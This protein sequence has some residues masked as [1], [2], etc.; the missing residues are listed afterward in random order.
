MI[1]RKKFLTLSSLGAIS[2]LFPNFIFS[3][4]NNEAAAFDLNGLLKNAKDLRKLGKNNEARQIYQQILIQFPNEIRAYDGL[5]KIIL[6]QKKKEWEVI[7]MFKAALIINP[8]NI[9]L[10]QRLYREYFNA[11]L[12]NKRIRATINFN[13]RLLA[14]VKQKFEIFLQSQPNNKSFQKQ[15]AKITRLLDCNADSICANANPTLKTYRKNSYKSFKNR[16][17]DVSTTALENKLNILMS[18]PHS[19]ERKLHIREITNLLVKRHRKD[20]NN[21][22]ALNKALLYHN[23][24]DNTDPLFLKYIRDL[25]KIEGNFDTLLNVEIQNHS[26][27]KSFWSALALIDVYI[28]KSEKMHTAL[29]SNVS[30]LLS[31]LEDNAYSPQKIFELTTRKIKVDLIKNQTENAK[32]KIL[33]ECKNMFGISNCHYIDRINVLTGMYF[34]KINDNDNLK[35]ILNVAIYPESFINDSDQLIK[36]LAHMNLN[37]SKSNFIHIQNL[38]KLLTKI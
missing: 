10:Q 11:V 32:I 3:K 23:N 8:N 22:V 25:S 5:R 28:R 20:K 14:D 9:E 15:H 21:S 34:K 18:K 36:S 27:K 29:P 12:G 38:N 17:N 26:I 1:T 30:S 24:I 31:F 6:S 19:A 13:G 4:Q 37:R 2:L 16:F 7:L 33:S 35:K